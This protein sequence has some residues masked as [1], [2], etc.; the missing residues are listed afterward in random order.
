MDTLQLEQFAP[1]YQGRTPRMKPCETLHTNQ[2]QTPSNT[3]NSAINVTFQSPRLFI[4]FKGQG[5]VQDELRS[6]TH[7]CDAHF[8]R[9]Q[10]HQQLTAA[11]L[12]PEAAGTLELPQSP[13][14]AALHAA[15]PGRAGWYRW[16]Y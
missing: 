11:M 6:S 2:R 1:R 15:R 13:R 12:L 10:H 4:I 9:R 5:F 14:N 8:A 3:S 7:G 16:G